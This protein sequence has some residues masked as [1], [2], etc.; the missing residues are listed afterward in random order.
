MNSFFGSELD[1]MIEINFYDKDTTARQRGAP[2]VGNKR[3]YDEGTTSLSSRKWT[4][5]NFV[6]KVAS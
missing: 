1:F 5:P 2:W 3:I 4:E 6:S